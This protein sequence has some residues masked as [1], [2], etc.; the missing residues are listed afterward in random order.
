MT[1][2]V[3]F[4]TGNLATHLYKA[5]LN[6][7]QVEV[8]AIWG[9]STPSKAQFGQA[10]MRTSSL[11]KIPEAAVYLICI[12]DDAVS[13]FSRQLSQEAFVVHTSGA[14]GLDVL[15]QARRGIF[16]PIQTFTKSKEVSINGVPICIEATNPKDVSTLK[17]L[18]K[19]I[20]AK[21]TEVNSA[22]RAYLHVAAVFVNNFVNQLYSSAHD[23]LESQKLSFDL[24]K[25]L[26]LET[27]NK[28]VNASPKSI[29]TGPAKRGD[30]SVMKSHKSLLNKEQ[31]KLYVT[32]SEAIYKTHN[33][34]EL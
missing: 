30:K 26:I 8:A 11:S 17:K 2:V 20:K 25:A 18:A 19:A 1:K 34:N 22:Q 32:L 14:L 15:T 4:G 21:P 6:A 9:R 3:I 7:Q 16:W 12:T 27:A 29:Q 5:F 31:Q 23:L 28:G 33:N 24:L 13:G 10:G